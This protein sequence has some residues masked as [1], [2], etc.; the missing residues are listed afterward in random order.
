MGASWSS[1]VASDALVGPLTTK[2]D[3]T[4]AA[5]TMQLTIRRGAKETT[6]DQKRQPRQEQRQNPWK[7]KTCERHLCEWYLRGRYLYE[8]V[9]VGDICVSDLSGVPFYGEPGGGN[10]GMQA[11]K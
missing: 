9:C 4:R 2:S 1:R 8:N 7:Q 5:Y 3:N 6:S 11:K 10:R